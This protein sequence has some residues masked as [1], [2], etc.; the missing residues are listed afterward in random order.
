M[1]GGAGLSLFAKKLLGVSAALAVLG[2]L[3]GLYVAAWATSAP[4]TITATTAP[5]SAAAT[6]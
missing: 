5:A 6:S 4:P 2:V 1:S 3:I